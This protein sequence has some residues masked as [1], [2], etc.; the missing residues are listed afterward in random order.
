MK[1][2]FLFIIFFSV[3]AIQQVFAQQVV[4]RIVATVEDV[5]ITAYELTNIAG[6]YNAKTPQELLNLV[7]DDYVIV[8][9]AKS[10]GINVSDED[11]DKTIEGFAEKNNMPKDKFL[12]KVKESGVD[13]DY[14][15]KGVKL[16]IYKQKFATKMFASSIKISDEDIDRYYVLHKNELNPGVVLILSIISTK[17]K[18]TAKIVYKGLSNGADFDKLK[19]Q[20]SLDKEKE[21]AIPISAFN[22]DIKDKL[23]QLK[24]GEY[25]NIIETNG[26]FYII[27]LIDKKDA[28]SDMELIRKHIRNILF[29][30]KM[31]SKLDSWLR[32]VK[33]RTDI[34]IF[35]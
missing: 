31:E 10:L 28:A 33:A 18:K 17:D 9:Y 19:Q 34:E 11:V 14:Y 30:K 15:F 12:S 1:K 2:L 20:F 22:K 27:K 24:K 6:F 23:L 29:A 35:E 7:V 4:D 13:M 25:S 21:R 3:F 8:H 26:K 32:M 5:P 16:Q